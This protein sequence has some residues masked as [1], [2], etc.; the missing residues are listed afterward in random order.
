MAG[1]IRSHEVRPEGY[2]I[3]HDGLCMTVFSAP[4]VRALAFALADGGS[5]AT[6]SAT[7]ERSEGST[8]PAPSPSRLSR[9][10]RI[11]M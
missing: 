10:S 6:R 4:N 2:S 8:M 7:P 3:E 9:L 1:L 11:P 5:T